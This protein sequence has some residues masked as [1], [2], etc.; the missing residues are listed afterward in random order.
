ME[1]DFRKD[2]GILGGIVDAMA[3]GVFTVDAQGKFVAWSDGAARITGY[4]SEEVVG[5]PCRILEGPNCKGF[6]TLTELLRSSDA[7]A[8]GICNQECKLMAK[9]GQELYIHGN[10]RLLTN[11]RGTVTGAVGTFTD[12]TSFVLAN[13][14]IA[15]LEKQAHIEGTF[16]RLVGHSQVM[17]EVFRRIRL[18]ADS[19]V[20]VLI[21]GQSGTGKELAAAA[22]H[23][24]SDRKHQPFLGVNCSAIPESLLESELFGHV[25]GAF[26]GAVRDKM[27]VFRAAHQGTLFLDE[28]GDVSP[29]MQ[30]KLL[31]ALQQREIRRVGDER[32]V[33]VDVRLIAATNKDLRG[34]IA[35]GDIREDFYYRI[36]VF[37]IQL[38]PLRQRRDDVPLLAEHFI[39]ELNESR[40][41]SVDGIARDAMQRMM[42]YPWPG[43]VRELRNAV[44]H[45]F[46]TV[47]GDRITYL[48]LPVEIRQWRGQPPPADAHRP[49]DETCD[50]RGRILEALER[51]SWNRTEAAKLLGFSRVTLW[52]KMG[53]Y[54][55]E[56]PG[57]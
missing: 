11:D 45:A 56:P 54:G 20:T 50:E 32:A 38:P 2:P 46:V 1:L 8:S 47:S 57:R 15:L 37:E 44:E 35:S 21:T 4:S 52:K 9:T 13:E 41:K 17:Q 31:R 7:A 10:V 26:T 49:N 43:N 24:R 48:D 40:G 51:T 28:I 42:E 25:K 23:S 30:V 27:G 14:K 12:V 34:L 16:E 22:I 19:D 33:K 3:L 36:R 53:R 18:A 39:Q 29:A 6:A 55:I 5:R